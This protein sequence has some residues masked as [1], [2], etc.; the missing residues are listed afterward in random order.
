MIGELITKFIAK[1]LAVSKTAGTAV[2]I[3]TLSVCETLLAAFKS[4]LV[5]DIRR[6]KESLIRRHEADTDAKRADAKR[7]LAEAATAANAVT[8]KSYTEEKAK[9]DLQTLALENAKKAAAVRTANANADKA[10]TAAALAKARALKE[11]F[12]EQRQKNLTEKEQAVFDALSKLIAEGGT[13]YIDA[14]ALEQLVKK[15]RSGDNPSPP[16]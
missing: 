9:L 10:E 14:P 15:L 7:K 3:A 8:P 5:P 6:I 12:D 16:H 4:R 2:S 11:F 13:L 1:P